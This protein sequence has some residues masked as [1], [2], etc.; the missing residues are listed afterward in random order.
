MHSVIVQIRLGIELVGFF[1][2]GVFLVRDAVNSEKWW[3]IIN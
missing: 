3:F 2:T 1:R